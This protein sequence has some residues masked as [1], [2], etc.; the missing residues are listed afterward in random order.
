MKNLA[1]Q[2]ETSHI[3]PLQTSS[4]EQP[5]HIVAVIGNTTSADVN[6]TDQFVLDINDG[7][8]DSEIVQRSNMPPI[9][10]VVTSG[11][12]VLALDEN[13]R[14]VWVVDLEK[15]VLESN[16]EDDMISDGTPLSNQWFYAG[17]F[18]QE[19][20]PDE[21]DDDGGMGM[22][23]NEQAGLHITCLSHAGHV[24]SVST[25]A[26][27]SISMKGDQSCEEGSE[28][29]GSFENGLECGGWSPDGEILALVTFADE[30][31]QEE[32]SDA[33]IPILMTMNTQ[34]EIL[35][36][37]RLDPCLSAEYTAEEKD[38]F[39]PNAIS[40]CWRPDSSSLAVSTMDA[41]VNNK[42][43]RR[44]RTFS[45]TLQLISLSKE[46]DG[47]GRDVPNLLSVSPTWAPAGCSHY[48]GVVQSSRPLTLKSAKSRQVSMQVAF[49][50]PNGLRHRECKIHNTCVAKKE[51]EE[52]IGVSF[53]LEGDLLSVTSTV[54]SLSDDSS[55]SYGKVQLYHRSNYHWYLKSELRFNALV[56]ATVFSADDPYKLTIALK[57]TDS[58]DNALEWRE[59]SFRW[60]AS[61]VYSHCQQSSALA[62]S[63]DG[64]KLNL[65]PLDKAMVPPPMYASH[66]EL[67][68]PVVAITARPSFYHE[69]KSQHEDRKIEFII[70]MSNGQLAVL[71]SSNNDQNGI[72]MIR[73]FEP[74]SLLA[75]IDLQ[76]IR[77]LVGESET[78][79]VT[80]SNLRDLTII[81]S[82]DR[83]MTMVAI[84][85]PQAKQH[86]YRNYDN[87]VEMKISWNDSASEEVNVDVFITE[88]IQLESRALRIVN[89]SD[90]AYVPGARGSALIELNDGALLEYT[91]GGTIES[92]EAGP[93]LE[94]CPSIAGIF[95]AHTEDISAYAVPDAEEVCH[96]VHS[97]RLSIGL[98]SRYRL[99]CGE[100]LLS[101]A[102]SSF[103]IS[104]PHKFVV[105]ATIGSRPHLHFLPIESLRDFDPF[106][107]SDN[108]AVLDGY[109]PRLVERGSRLVSIFPSSPSL[110]LQMPRG[111]LEGI[112]PRA[113]VLPYVMA[114]I[115]K[116]ELHEAFDIMRRQRVDLNLIVDLDP[117]KFLSCGAEQLV[118][119][120]EQIDNINL[121]ISSLTEVDSTYKYPVPPWIRKGAPCVQV[122]DDDSKV[123]MVCRKMRELML[124]AEKD[125]MTTSGKKVTKGHF[126]LPILSTFAKESPP[127]VEEALS[128]IKDSATTV[129]AKKQS[130]GKSV[131]FSDYVQ[132]SIQYLAFLADYELIFNTALGMYDFDL[133]KAVARHS[134]MDPKV[135]LPMLKGLMKLP[136]FLAR[137]EVDIKLKRFDTALRN[138]VASR[139]H[140]ET[141]EETTNHQNKCMAFI[142]EHS[143][144]KLGL[145]LF[146]EDAAFCHCIMASL[147]ERLLAERKPEEA[148]TIFLL[149]D[150]KCLDGGKRAARACGDWKAFFACCAEDNETLSS[151]Q[152][153]NIAELISSKF[154]GMKEQSDAYASAARILQDY[155]QDFSYSVDMLISGHLWSE[156]RRVAYLQNRSD[157]V[158]KVIDASISYAQ[159]CID[160]MVDRAST[161]EKTNTRYAEVIVMRRNAI[162]EAEEAGAELHDDSASIFSMQSTASNTSLRSSAS[163]RSMGSVGSVGTV[164][165]VSTVISVGAT[166]T[167]SFTGDIDT[168]KHKSKFNK[169]GRDKKKKQKKPRNSRRRK[170]GGEEELTELVNTLTHSCPDGHYVDV[171]S[172]TITFLLQSGKRPMAELLL[173]AYTNL[174]DV[175]LKSQTERL[176]QDRKNQ[177]EIEK[178]IR[179]EGGIYQLVQHPCEK[180]VDALR[181]KP[182]PE[183]LRGVFSFLL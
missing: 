178:S 135:Y 82:D 109:E 133:A 60:E 3:I 11:G 145:E 7:D 179:V 138:L 52:V 62:M 150:P 130:K 93:L 87:L 95:D 5:G 105:H 26:T 114:K 92:C 68:A 97:K 169:I 165:S 41:N 146:Q 162:K 6:F 123:N 152:A 167:F 65:T 182:L 80:T 131:L 40:F 53:N 23:I 108:H 127:K 106:T 160:D 115:Q 51:K 13:D 116:G 20:S 85:C 132:S 66:L 10:F 142:E 75:I 72:T 36:E 8:G 99:Y 61:N 153:T 166:S 29:I 35:S 31:E 28:C 129:K 27:T 69:S 58:V 172:S 111:N 159:T 71:G 73:G 34:Y 2:G 121:F 33:K 177:E 102:S 18:M 143:L 19:I 164:A 63:V 171:I 161:F 15:V 46:E 42:P 125:G 86:Q 17:S 126:L 136:K 76:T 39:D 120:I 56:S 170:P 137:F 112:S 156:G 148:L 14:L 78:K 163:G 104:L 50:E 183:T 77:C 144:H 12:K 38:H 4:D 158:K 149:A 47:S 98:S 21:L 103:E 168:M 141:D 124:T 81:D 119:Q 64:K 25:G 24:V 43:L 173:D 175:V 1:L 49:M 174:E 147:G 128:L 101:S 155:C 74:P 30:D 59:Y 91:E 90:T 157:L 154:G 122:H 140:H 44:V 176:D 83:S 118:C 110:V 96:D 45:T 16:E 100:R 181:C 94:P 79:S 54:T 89:W 37:V 151:E 22:N 57:R 55:A 70:T 180:D 84:C 32:G 113:V 107:E 134:Q 139:T 117:T 88:I 67:P 48:V 9:V